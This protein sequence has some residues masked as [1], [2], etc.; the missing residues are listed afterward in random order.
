ML[1]TTQNKD[2]AE[3]GSRDDE[4]GSLDSLALELGLSLDAE[5]LGLDLRRDRG[6][7]VGVCLDCDPPAPN[8]AR[9][10]SSNQ[11]E[12]VLGLEGAEVDFWTVHGSKIQNTL[13]VKKPRCLFLLFLSFTLRRPTKGTR[14][15]RWETIR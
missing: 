13:F 7:C 2:C 1:S 6:G 8:D 12:Y 11:P 4:L 14:E 5:E 10:L 15:R 9:P 3:D